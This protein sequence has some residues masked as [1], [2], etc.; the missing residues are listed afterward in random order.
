MPVF[1]CPGGGICL[2]ILYRILPIGKTDPSSRYGDS[3][4]NP[5]TC[6]N[7]FIIMAITGEV[8]L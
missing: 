6:Y 5:L 7:K 4:H 3:N 1:A 8:Q 2:Y